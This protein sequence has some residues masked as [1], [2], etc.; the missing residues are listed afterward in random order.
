MALSGYKY[1]TVKQE[2]LKFE[3]VDPLELAN[4][5]K[6]K[7]KPKPGCRAFYVAPFD[8]RLPHPRKLI[9]KNYEILAQNEK[10]KALFPRSNLIASSRRLKN[11]GEILSPTVQPS[12]PKA[13]QHQTLQPGAGR[14]RGR[15]R[16]RGATRAGGG[17]EN[18]QRM[19]PQR[20]GTYHCEYFRKS[21]KCDVCQHMVE[22]NH[23]YS[24]HYKVKHSIA[25]NNVHLK[26][27]E[28][29]KLRW[30]IYPKECIHPGGNY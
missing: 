26:A 11:L 16:G 30:F 8:P 18:P 3:K 1:E 24:H 2:L 14:G 20:N 15:G 5:S 10:A 9:S 13:G 25:G 29:P 4:Q 28:N 27:T 21:R 7:Q 17:S 22:S 12:I 19:E 23:V 6:K